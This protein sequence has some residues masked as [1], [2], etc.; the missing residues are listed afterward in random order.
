MRQQRGATL[1]IVL[2]LLVV[3]TI[4]GTIAVRQGRVGLNI[5]T[6]SQ[7]Q[8]LLIQ[9]SDAAFFNVEKED[10]LI[11]AL[12]TSGM[13]GY[14]SGAANQD[15]ELVFCFRGAEHDFFNIGRAS[16][17]Q[18]EEGKQKPTNNALGTDGYC[19]AKAT[20]SNFFT[21]GRRVVMTQVAV[22]FSSVQNND[23]FFGR[24]MGTDE[25]RVKLERSKPVKIFAVSIMPTL[26]N[27]DANK[28]NTCLN[29]HMNEVTIP[30]GVNIG[31]DEES[32]T[33]FE[34]ASKSVT[35]CLSELNVPFSTYVT[36][37]VLAQDFV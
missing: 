6:N 21:S 26:T 31:D 17:M 23:P 20:E 27:T 16:I 12:S 24:V 2:I 3:I 30:R 22:K 25:E 36:E 28:I 15:K 8:Q 18:W 37:Y 33:A 34:Q 5:A 14:I 9:S 35:Q 4:I 11:Q 13:F 29:S 32:K 10:N 1:I 19:D 7:A